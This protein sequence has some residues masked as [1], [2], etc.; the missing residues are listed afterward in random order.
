MRKTAMLLLVCI[1]GT[2][3]LNAAESVQ[4]LDP[5][6]RQRYFSNMLSIETENHITVSGGA[7]DFGR[8]GGYISSYASGE[9]TTEWIPYQGPNQISRRE[10]FS[11]A[12][13]MDIAEEEERIEKRNNAQ[14][15]AGGI[16]LGVGAVAAVAG[17][18]W[19]WNKTDQD[20][21]FWGALGLTCGG[22][23]ASCASI[24]LFLWETKSDISIAFAANIADS[25]NKDL[26]SSF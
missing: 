21:C 5:E 22:V 17:M 4:A 19:G 7:Y 26:L 14:K 23:V 13:L 20:P 10:F 25:F 16:V 8:P 6:Q 15:I 9:T 1:I 2:M 24:P 12:G 18:I 11:I 3:A